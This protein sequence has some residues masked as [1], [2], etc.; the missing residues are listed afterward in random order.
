ML[1]CPSAVEATAEG[2]PDLGFESVV[3]D[4]C[5]VLAETNC[6]FSIAGFGQAEWPVDVRYDLS[7][8]VEQL[9]ELLSNIRVRRSA[10]IDLYGQGIERTLRFDVEGDRIVATCVSR[11]GWT[12]SPA[13]EE[14]DYSELLEMLDSV[15]FEFAKFLRLVWPQCAGMVPFVDWLYAR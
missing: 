12:P 14:L 3:M 7:T 6:A 11:T 15:A 2:P 13:K 9:P 1:I 10:E 5:S 4:L 8:L